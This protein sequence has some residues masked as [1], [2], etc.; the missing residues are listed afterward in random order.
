MVM[1]EYPMQEIGNLVIS[2]Q[3]M[4]KIAAG[5]ELFRGEDGNGRLRRVIV[6]Q[7]IMQNHVQQ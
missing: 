3:G 6:R 4:R 2:A 7:L 1:G 5:L